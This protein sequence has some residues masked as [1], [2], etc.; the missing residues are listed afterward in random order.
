MKNLTA[1]KEGSQME[2]VQEIASLRWCSQGS[3]VDDQ[4]STDLVLYSCPWK[5]KKKLQASD[6]G[7]LSRLL[8]P[9][10]EVKN[11]II[12]LMSDEWVGKIV[13]RDGMS[14][15]VW[16]RDTDS[17]HALVLRYWQSSGCFVLNGH[18]IENFVLRRR[19]SLGDEIGLFW[20]RYDQK[21]YFSVLQRGQPREVNLCGAKFH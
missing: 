13:S 16:D 4:V 8:L 14:V 6:L 15:T 9:K 1:K 11:H 12:P 5:I 2:Q 7:G 17:Y 20:S 3:H 18:W 19:L 21:L 10:N